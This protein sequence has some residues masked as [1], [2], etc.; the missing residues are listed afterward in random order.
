MA[1]N[2]GRGATSTAAAALRRAA[3]ALPHHPTSS[4]ALPSSSAG[5][6]SADDAPHGFFWD[7]LPTLV[8]QNILDRVYAF[9]GPH[10]RAARSA[11][12]STCRQLNSIMCA[13]VRSFG[14]AAALHF[15]HLATRRNAAQRI[16]AALAKY[17][18]LEALHI[19]VSDSRLQSVVSTPSGGGSGPPLNEVDMVTFLLHC[20]RH[21]GLKVR[22]VSVDIGPL[23]GAAVAAL[24]CSLPAA[25]ELSLPLVHAIHHA[26]ASLLELQL[27][28]GVLGS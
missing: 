22:A 20:G 19:S 27:S 5:S 4:A 17:T 1:D 24:A 9:E 16:E 26:G 18:S 6:G 12:A 13:T 23:S 11:L 8:L 3:A 10:G 25:Q 14:N 28:S 2:S 15:N 21:L 7:D